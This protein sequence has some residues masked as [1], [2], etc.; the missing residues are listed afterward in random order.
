MVSPSDGQTAFHTKQF[1]AIWG[2]DVMK[3]KNP[4]T[5]RITAEWIIKF[6]RRW[7]SCWVGGRAPLEVQ[8]AGRRRFKRLLTETNIQAPLIGHKQEINQHGRRHHQRRKRLSPPP[9]LSRSFHSHKPS[10]PPRS[11]W[12]TWGLCDYKANSIFC[13]LLT[14]RDGKERGRGFS[15]DAAWKTPE[16]DHVTN[17]FMSPQQQHS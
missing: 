9:P 8:G 2:G 10:P 3:E 5:Q 12:L 11:H 4:C 7:G 15:V 1:S 6:Q 13:P 16:N 14:E 17:L